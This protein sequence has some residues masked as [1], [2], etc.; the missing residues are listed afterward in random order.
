[1]DRKTLE[2]KKI[3]DLRA[4]A[5]SLGIENSESL[6]KTELVDQIAGKEVSA[7]VPTKSAES[8]EVK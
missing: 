8:I 7:K 1:M 2:T 6:K 3:S 4:M 5:Q